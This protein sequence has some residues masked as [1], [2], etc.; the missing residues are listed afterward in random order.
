MGLKSPDC[1]GC[2]V[3]LCAQPCLDVVGDNYGN[4]DS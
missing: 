4:Y 1:K 3:G 2:V